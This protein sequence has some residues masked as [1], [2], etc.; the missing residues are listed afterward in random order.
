MAL[1]LMHENTDRTHKETTNEHAERECWMSTEIGGIC[2]MAAWASAQLA[3]LVK[4]T[5]NPSATSRSGMIALR[6]EHAESVRRIYATT[7]N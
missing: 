2:E 6:R 1:A 7:Q 5:G 4:Q 3:D